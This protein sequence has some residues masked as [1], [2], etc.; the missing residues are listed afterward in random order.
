MNS[1]VWIATGLLA[2][3]FT[4]SGACKATLSKQKLIAGGQTGV[5]FV[6]S[7]AIRLIAACELAAVVALIVPR[8]AD[9]GQGL[10]VAAAL[11]L[12]ALMVGAAVTHTML[13]EP[14]NIA[15][16]AVLFAVAG[17]VAIATWASL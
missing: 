4:I 17:F 5:V 1:A 12:C 8:L 15:I 6:P 9:R 2:I 10:T 14:R 13:R 11:G 3:V 16:N 7:W